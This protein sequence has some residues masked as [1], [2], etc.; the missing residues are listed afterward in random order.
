MLEADEILFYQSFQG[1]ILFKNQQDLVNQL[2]SDP[3]TK[4]Y[5]DKE[6]IEAYRKAQGRLKTYISQL[7]S[8][9]A[10][11]SI[12]EEFRQGLL[13]L[14]EKK[15]TQQENP[16]R[17]VEKIIN[18][19]RLKNSDTSRNDT[20]TTLSNQFIT[21]VFNAGYIAVITSKPLEVEAKFNLEEF[22]LRKTIFND[23]IDS[24]FSPDIEIKYYRFNFPLESTATLFWKGLRKILFK[25]LKGASNNERLFS[26][27]HRKLQLKA[28]RNIELFQNNH[29]NDD[30]LNELTDEILEELNNNRHILV[31]VT[32]AP[33]YST[34]IIALNP[35]ESKNFKLYTLL[36]DDSSL[37]AIYK[38]T[39]E[40]SLLWRIFVWDQLKSKL[41]AGT[42]YKYNKTNVE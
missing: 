11:R 9:S 7:L 8:S 10:T 21:D 36:S 4:Y 26:I 20:K 17:V 24:L 28:N 39:S 41:F 42:N 33:I 27:L 3:K 30:Y 5:K 35:A 2:L 23:F 16:E 34:P 13:V 38:Y 31:L 15:L 14:L 32:K 37:P 19:L 40:E 22:S 25:Q 6:D 29:I 1:G 18:S 12:T